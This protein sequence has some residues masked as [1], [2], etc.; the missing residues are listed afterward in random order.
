MTEQTLDRVA[1]ALATG[2]PRRA[3]MKAAAAAA[4][5]GA[6]TMVVRHEDVHAR[7]QSVEKCCNTQHQKWD[8]YCRRDGSTG[9]DDATFVCYAQISQHSSCFVERFDCIR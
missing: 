9:V 1:R 6:I 4:V 5:G 2:M 3:V 8:S 7:G